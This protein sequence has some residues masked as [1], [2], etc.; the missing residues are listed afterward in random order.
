M[1]KIRGLAL[2][3][4]HLGEE[5][6]LLNIC[7]GKKNIVQTT[8]KKIAELSRGNAGFESGIEKLILIGDIVELSEAEDQQ[9]YDTANFFF[10]SLL[11]EVSVQ[12]IIYIVGNHDHHLWVEALK[13]NQGKEHYKDCMPKTNTFIEDAE[14]FVK[15]CLPADHSVGKISVGYPNYTVEMDDSCFFFD[16]GHLFSGLLEKL[17]AAEDANNLEDL[18]EKTY[19][20]VEFIWYQSKSRIKE[21]LWDLYLRIRH[22]IKYGGRGTSYDVDSHSVFDDFSRRKIIWYLTNICGIKEDTF[23]K[24]F[25]FVFGHTHHGGRVLKDDRKIRVKGKFITVWNTGG[26]V[27][28]SKVFSPDAYIFYIEQTE[29]GVKPL[30]YKLVAKRDPTEDGDYPREVLDSILA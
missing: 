26:W 16:H 1:K 10:S 3:D 17:T 9:A 12:E 24:D 25:H 15:N 2:S 4:L 21:R 23:K 18:E 30:A 11:S 28:P 27:V 5:E 29:K 22:G 13:Q 6:G 14:I 7:E 8:V 20:E 19:K